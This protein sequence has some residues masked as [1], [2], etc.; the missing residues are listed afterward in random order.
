MKH[1]RMVIVPRRPMN[2]MMSIVILLMNVRL[3]VRLSERPTVVKAE[4]TSKIA[5]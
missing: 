4:T 5:Y 3:A 2:I 1:E